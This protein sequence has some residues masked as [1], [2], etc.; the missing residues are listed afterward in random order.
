MQPRNCQHTFLIAILALA[1]LPATAVAN[2]ENQELAL[3]LKQLENV[4]TILKRAEVQ[5]RSRTELRTSRYEFDYE[6]IRAD[7]QRVSGGIRSYIT[8][9]RSQPRDL[10]DIVGDY[11]HDRGNP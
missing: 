4:D 3:A 10:G 8:P 5:A 11:S 7:L 9:T 6:L 1:L 2:Q